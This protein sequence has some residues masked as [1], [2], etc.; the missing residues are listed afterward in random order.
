[1]SA[2]GVAA[3]SDL[4]EITAEEIEKRRNARVFCFVD[5]EEIQGFDRA[6]RLML[7]ELHKRQTSMYMNEDNIL[8]Y[9]HG[10]NWVRSAREDDEGPKMQTL[11]TE[12][13]IPHQSIVDNDLSLI[14]SSLQNA[15]ESLSAQFSR[16]IYSVVGAAA[17]RV[18]NVVSNKETGSTAQSFLEMLKKIEFGVDREGNVSLPQMH[19]GP[20]MAEKL[21]N[22]LKSQPPEFSEE[23]E[24]VKAERSEL[25]LQKEAER[26]AK[27]KVAT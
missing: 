27:F 11:S 18:G 5:D 13:S 14:T 8:H 17:E 2:L 15:A 23:V 24:R 22:E 3:M 21:I 4:V 7:R 26:K 16:S 12:W 25:A 9:S 1:M 20:D 10:A 19:V 6:Y